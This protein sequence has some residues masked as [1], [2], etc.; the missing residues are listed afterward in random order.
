M[1]SA[2]SKNS[3]NTCGRHDAVEAKAQRSRLD[4]PRVFRSADDFSQM[5]VA[6]R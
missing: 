2:D 5:F 6:G 1:K 3:A 4:E